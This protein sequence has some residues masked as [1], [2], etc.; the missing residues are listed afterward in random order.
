LKLPKFTFTN[1]NLSFLTKH[2]DKLYKHAYLIAV[3]VLAVIAFALSLPAVNTL[4]EAGATKK[5]LP[6]YSVE[7]GD[8]KIS[9]SFDAAWGAD[10]TQEILDIL[11]EF[12]VRTTFFLCGYWVDKHPDEVRSIHAAGH[13]I[14]NHGD[15]HA[16]GAQLSLEQ[17]KREIMGPHQ[18]I[19]DLLGIEMNLFR[20]PYGEYNNTVLDAAAAVNYYVIQWDV[21]SLDWKNKG[22]EFEINQVLNNK[23]LQNGSI[24]LFHNDATDTP[25]VLD[26]IIKGLK[27]KGYEIVP[28]SQLIHKENFHMDHT[29]R[30][31]LNT[32]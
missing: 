18:K 6:I 26:Q 15:T 24:I 32:P 5:K 14:A 19:K 20:A 28:I 10:D 7:R 21:D 31:I 3:A 23:N 4:V 30:Q 11:A 2:K 27:E 17:N 1:I 12:N 22:V 13:D 25:A 8:N 16:H 29:G 9:I